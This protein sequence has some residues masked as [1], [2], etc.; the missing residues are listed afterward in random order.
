MQLYIHDPALDIPP[1]YKDSVPIADR[2]VIYNTYYIKIK[3]R[4][5]TLKSIVTVYRNLHK[6]QMYIIIIVFQILSLE[7][8]FKP[9]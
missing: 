4:T 2:P 6:S 1:R 3:Y 8:I 7:L 9:L 5:L